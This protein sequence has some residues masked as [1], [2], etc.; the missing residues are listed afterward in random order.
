MTG[1]Q[2][3]GKGTKTVSKPEPPSSVNIHSHHSQPSI[4]NNKGHLVNANQ[5][6][7]IT[8]QVDKNK[9]VQNVP[10]DDVTTGANDSEIHNGK[11]S[12]NNAP[13]AQLPTKKTWA[14]L[15]ANEPEKWSSNALAETKGVVA[16][17]SAKA[18]LQAQPQQMRDNRD[19]R[20]E[21]QKNNNR[22]NSDTSLSIYVKGVTHSMSYELLKAAF[23]TFGHVKH[24]DVVH[25]KSCAFVEYNNAESYRRALE[26]H[27]VNV[28][29][30]TVN[31][32]ERRVR[33][34]NGKAPRGRF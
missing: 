9:D 29:S 30:E 28:G 2:S 24:L 27:T 32:E 5:Q 25:T 26:A 6:V 15:A 23:M 17:V 13:Q 21:G 7:N 31:T 11:L 16:S 12:Y 18:V 34:N 10:K 20:S 22:R 8:T 3:N 4:V 33:R 1:S 14:S 19:R